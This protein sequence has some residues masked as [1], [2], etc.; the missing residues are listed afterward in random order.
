M[1]RTGTIPRTMLLKNHGIIAIGAHAFEVKAA[2][3]MAEKAAQVFAGAAALGG[4]VGMAGSEVA[5]IASRLDEH[6][7]QWMLVKDAKA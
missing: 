7:R 5:R 6:H 3:F 4:P 2:L 1:E